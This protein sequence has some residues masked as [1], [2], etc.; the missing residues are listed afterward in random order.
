MGSK[1]MFST[2]IENSYPVI[3]LPDG[4]KKRIDEMEKAG[5]YRYWKEDLKLVKEMRLEFLRYG[6][7]YYKVH[8]GPGIYDWSFADDTFHYLQE[9][10]ITPIVDL[11][12]FGVP[13]WIGNFQNSD[14]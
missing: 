14:W 10:E 2:G 7:P 13:D 4:K 5:H 11:C 9:L 8:A 6:P 12:H 3:Q 1:F